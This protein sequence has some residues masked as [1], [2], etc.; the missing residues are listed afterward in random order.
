MKAE[1][2]YAGGYFRVKNADGPELSMAED[3]FIEKDGYLFKDL[4][5]TGELLP[6]EDW[7]LPREERARDLASRLTVEEI[8]GLMQYSRHQMVPA[9]EGGPFPGHYQGKPFEAALVEASALTDEQKRF[10]KED[11]LRHILLAGVRDVRTSASW[12]NRMQEE[13]EKGAG[14]IAEKE[15]ISSLKR[16]K[17]KKIMTYGI[18]FC[19]KAC[20]VAQGETFQSVEN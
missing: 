7:R 11:H 10:L 12:S 14:Q 9:P 8:A 18:A 13:A 2:T 17:Y 3:R 19:Q 5:G 6:Y 1:K 15:Y 20:S 16:A 4:A